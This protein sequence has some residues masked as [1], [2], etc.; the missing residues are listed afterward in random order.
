[1][2]DKLLRLFVRFVSFCLQLADGSFNKRH[3]W[4][5]SLTSSPAQLLTLKEWWQTLLALLIY[6]KN[7]Q[8][9]NG[10]LQ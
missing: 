3:S 4:E 1:M 5:H 8:E 6:C 2:N 7:I 10:L 9:D